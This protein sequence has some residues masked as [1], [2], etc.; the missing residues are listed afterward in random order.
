[1]G[2]DSGLAAAGARQDEQRAA[3]VG[4]GLP[5][6]GVQGF[7]DVQFGDASLELYSKCIGVFTKAFS[8]KP[9]DWK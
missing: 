2:D 4:G 1:M 9:D 6:R 7:D 5:L 3:G 8:K